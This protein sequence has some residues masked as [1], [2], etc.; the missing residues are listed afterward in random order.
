[1]LV[2]F[3]KS[4]PLEDIFFFFFFCRDKLL[5]EV[6][7][8][9]NIPHTPL[10]LMDTLISGILVCSLWHFISGEE[11]E[12]LLAFQPKS[13]LSNGPNRGVMLTMAIIT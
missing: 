9:A 2:V 6:V 1:M 4:L 5:D 3:K 12:L 7:M 11:E 13:P 10:D 8:G